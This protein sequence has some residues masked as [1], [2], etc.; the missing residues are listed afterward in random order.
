MSASIWVTIEKFMQQ[1]VWLLL[2]LILAPIVGPRSYGQFAI[3]M[4]F[5]GFCEFVVIETT[6]ESLIGMQPLHPKHLGTANLFGIV[7]SLLA[8]GILFILAPLIGSEFKDNQLEPIFKAL[9]VLP[10]IS[11]LT[12]APLAVL[13]SEMRFKPIA[14][15]STLGLIIGGIAGVILAFNG[16][17]VWSL[18]A[19]ILVQRTTE[20]IILWSSAR[21]AAKIGWSKPHFTDLRSFAISV[22][23]SRSLGFT[24]AQVPRL[25]LGFFLGAYD[26]GLF[27]FA[28][29]IPDILT[30]I[31]IVPTTI[32]A[33]TE[34]RKYVPNQKELKVAFKHL[35]QDTSLIAFPACIGLAVVAPEL[36]K[37]GLDSRWQAAT[38]AT[39]MLILSVIPLVIF[40]SAGFLL[41]AM[42]FPR[43]E[44]KISMGHLVGSLF[45]TLIAAPF[46]LKIVCFVLMIRGIAS[47][48]LPL[49]IISQKCG[50][51][52]QLV[53][54]AVGPALISSISMGI[55]VMLLNQIIVDYVGNV[56]SI[57]IL[58]S[59]GVIAYLVTGNIIGQTTFES[60]R[61]L[62]N[63]HV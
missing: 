31:T 23:I 5:I 2:F 57:P 52:P 6:V 8:G 60:L 40:Y 48:P 47:L 30:A 42:N 3:V 7:L 16:A 38:F 29:R 4:V 25:I 33:R 59:I 20:V 13:R 26:L 24:A 28:A 62:T 12:S 46:G 56:F 53:G 34:M 43:D 51:S 55:I 19:Q 35:L 32:V 21:T 36:I 49:W 14:I 15:R 61:R 45:C 39:Q 41:W 1:A 37:V 44:S 17:G 9:S 10:T 54:R 11:S 50:I 58:I 18:V 22:L 63:R 27:V